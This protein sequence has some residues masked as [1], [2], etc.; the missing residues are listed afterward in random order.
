MKIKLQDSRR[1][2]YVFKIPITRK[3]REIL[4][5]LNVSGDEI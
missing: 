4:K 1:E 3:H 5:Q 2:I